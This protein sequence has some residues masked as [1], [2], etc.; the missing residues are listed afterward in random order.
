GCGTGEQTAILQDALPESSILGI[1]SSK[2]MLAQSPLFGRP[3]I[4]FRWQEVQ[5]VLADK[6]QDDLVFSNAALQWLD[7]HDILFPKIV[8]LI[9]PAGQLAIQ[10]PVQHENIL[11][12][13]LASLASSE[14]YAAML[15]GYVQKSSVLSIDEY[16]QLL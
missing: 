14:P 16:T 4:T 8:Q 15:K 11:N 10:M 12:R 3:G 2:E 6:K 7:R 13:I 9:A 5:D 1:D